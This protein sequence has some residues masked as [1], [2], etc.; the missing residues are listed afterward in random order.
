MHVGAALELALPQQIIQ[1]VRLRAKLLR[2]ADVVAAQERI[3]RSSPLHLRRRDSHALLVTADS[4]K[5]QAAVHPV[6]QGALL[7]VKK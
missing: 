5:L 6:L 1:H 4:H 2:Q 3:L 7:H